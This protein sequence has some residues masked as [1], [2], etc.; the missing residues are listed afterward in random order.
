VLPEYNVLAT[1]TEM[2]HNCASSMFTSKETP[3]TDM[4]AYFLKFSFLLSFFGG[5]LSR[6]GLGDVRKEKVSRRDGNVL[7]E[8][9][10][11][12]IGSLLLV[13]EICIL[14]VLHLLRS[15]F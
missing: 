13:S 12:R 15:K 6:H 9:P 10:F 7:L 3:K 8:V 5:C 1:M 14:P 11:A 2:K 4:T